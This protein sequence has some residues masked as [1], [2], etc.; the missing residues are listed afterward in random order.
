MKQNRR[1]F[2]GWLAGLF[3]VGATGASSATLTNKP[4][5]IEIK[6]VSYHYGGFWD[7]YMYVDGMLLRHFSVIIPSCSM[8]FSNGA[9][10]DRQF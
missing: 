5:T 1:N 6:W 7:H 9:L 2:I 8:L 4:V 10:P 3:A